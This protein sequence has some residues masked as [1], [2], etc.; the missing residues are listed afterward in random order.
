MKTVDIR[1][2]DAKTTQIFFTIVIA[3]FSIRTLDVQ[4]FM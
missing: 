4:V 3:V 1:K 2:F